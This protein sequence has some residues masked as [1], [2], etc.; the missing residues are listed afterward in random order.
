[1][2]HSLAP[3]LPS[4]LVP[5]IICHIKLTAGTKLDLSTKL[6]KKSHGYPTEHSIL[7]SISMDAIAT[8]KES[9]YFSSGEGMKIKYGK[10]NVVHSSGN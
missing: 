10:M 9:P 8:E 7:C 2:F 6:R 1:M 3:P 5:I 4:I